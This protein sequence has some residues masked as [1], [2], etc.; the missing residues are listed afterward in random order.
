MECDGI[1]RVHNVQ[2]FGFVGNAVALES[3]PGGR[4]AKKGDDECLGAHARQQGALF[5]LNFWRRVEE[6]HRNTPLDRA[7]SKTVP[8]RIASHT[9]RLVLQAAFAL[10]LGLRQV[11][12]VNNPNVPDVSNQKGRDQ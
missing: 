7:Q 6:F 5:C 3:V 11:A 9:A 1:N 2:A 8:F 12:R 4:R 10:L